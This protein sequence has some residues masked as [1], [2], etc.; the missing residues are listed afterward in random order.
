VSHYHIGESLLP[1]ACFTLE[2]IDVLDRMKAS[3]TWQVLRSEFDQLLLDNA[4][5][6]GPTTVAYVP[7]KGWFWYIP[8]PDDVVSVGVVAEKDYLYNGTR[9][10]PGIFHN[11]VKKNARIEQHLAAGQRIADVP[12]PLPHGNPLIAGEVLNSCG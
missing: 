7:E 12:A 9:D 2:R 5:E 4:R 8:L 1:Y 3:M 10:L 11:Q 6:K